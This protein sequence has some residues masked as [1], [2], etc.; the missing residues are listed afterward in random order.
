MAGKDVAESLAG[1]GETSLLDEDDGQSGRRR[2]EPGGEAEGFSESAPRPFVLPLVESD[3]AELEENLGI[4]GS[5]AV[6][7]AEHLL[8]GEVHR[9]E[10]DG[11]P[12]ISVHPL[13]RWK[14]ALGHETGEEISGFGRASALELEPGELEE[15]PGVPGLEPEGLR[16]RPGALVEM[17]LIVER[18]GEIAPESRFGGGEVGRAAEEREP[19]LVAAQEA[20]VEAGTVDDEGVVGMV[21]EELFEAPARARGV[22][23]A[24]DVDGRTEFKSED[25]SGRE[26]A[27]RAGRE[28]RA[29]PVI[30]PRGVSRRTAVPW[31]PS[32]VPAV[33]SFVPSGSSKGGG[34]GSWRPRASSRGPSQGA[35]RRQRSTERRLRG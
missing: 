10:G 33:Q 4:A 30:I 18:P 21:A 7:L 15:S 13:A 14:T 8:R 2:L 20:E 12:D 29:H 5:K 27:P 17:S 24:L 26:G 31:R 28:G 16:K 23:T 22:S 11:E 1:L 19:F 32:G 34:R 3:L 35:K 6:R 9:R 25:A